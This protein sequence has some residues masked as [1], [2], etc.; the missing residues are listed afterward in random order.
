MKDSF[1]TWYSLYQMTLFILCA[2][3]VEW[4]IEGYVIYEKVCATAVT[5]MLLGCV[6]NEMILKLRQK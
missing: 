3:L 6:I 4:L 1:L 2:V 5:G